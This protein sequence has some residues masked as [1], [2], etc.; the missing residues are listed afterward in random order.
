MARS[1]SLAQ[2]RPVFVAL[3][4]G[5]GSGKTWLAT[6]LQAQFGP[7]ATR[8]CLDDF[9]R[10]LSHRSLPQRERVNFDHPRAIDWQTLEQVLRDALAGKTTRIP[11]YDFATHCRLP[12]SAPWQPSPLVLVDGLWL[13]RRPSLRQLFAYRV[14]IECPAPVRL[15]RRLERDMRERGR[16]R[17][18]VIEQFQEEV[19]PMHERFV[20]SQAR[21]ADLVL[22]SPVST[23][24]VLEIAARL[25]ALLPV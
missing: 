4:G 15:E 20:A 19:A 16:T 21:W 22:A 1:S 13:L 7:S 10:D 18:S 17:T 8:L 3:A 5:S 9:Y 12:A 25:R 23:D 24:T 11:R 2:P 14:F 6:A